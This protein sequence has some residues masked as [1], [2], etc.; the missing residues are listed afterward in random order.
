MFKI[1]PLYEAA[2]TGGGETLPP[3]YAI[4]ADDEHCFLVGESN[5]VADLAATLARFLETGEQSEPLDDLD[6]KLGHRWLTVSQAATEY[7]MPLSTVRY[8]APSIPGARMVAN[9][10]TFPEVRFR[11]VYVRWRER[12]E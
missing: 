2:A 10:W 1:H 5:E 9:R 11:A 4:C 12:N 7:G 8:Y 3:M 6:E